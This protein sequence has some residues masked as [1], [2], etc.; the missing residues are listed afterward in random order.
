MKKSPN[1]NIKKTAPADSL[2]GGGNITDNW[3]TVYEL[4]EAEKRFEA[5][6]RATSDVIYRMSPDWRVMYQLVGRNFIAD[7]EGPTSTWLQ[8][9]IPPEDQP[10]VIAV[11]KKAIRTK[12]VF[13]LE[14][15]ILRPDGSLGWTFSRAIPIFDESGGI[16]S[17]FGMASDITERK[18]AKEALKEALAELELRHEE[19][20]IKTKNLQE[21]NIALKVL[22][23]HRVQEF[24]EIEKTFLAKI[25]KLVFPYLE[26]LSTKR[27]QSEIKTFVEIIKSHLNEIVQPHAAKLSNTLSKLTPTENKI[28]DFVRLGK[29][30]K[31]IA[32]LMDLS[33]AT[34]STHRQNIRKKL[35]LTNKKINLQSTLTYTE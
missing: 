20:K 30:T 21:A 14:H 31:E 29:T 17:W 15:R 9:Y 34:I 1:N 22:L 32:T 8:K 26:K 25:E 35:D 7:M 18:K 16:A 24:E 10:Q 12:T 5:L 2:V 4:R 11:I 3:K 23:E 33:Q 27:S 19:L 13:E 28:A 6:L